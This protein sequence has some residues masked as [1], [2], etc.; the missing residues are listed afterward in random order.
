MVLGA[1]DYLTKP[2]DLDA[3]VEKIKKAADMQ[4]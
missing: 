1:L 2:C 4:R 3:L